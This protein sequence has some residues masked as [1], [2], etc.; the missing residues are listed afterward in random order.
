MILITPDDKYNTKDAYALLRV[1]PENI[2][3]QAVDNLS[4]M[5][6]LVKSRIDSGRVPGRGINVSEK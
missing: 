4:A 1:Y 5:G 3:K 6:M 2:I